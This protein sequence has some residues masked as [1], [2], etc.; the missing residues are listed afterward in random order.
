MPRTGVLRAALGAAIALS[1]ACARVP[2]TQLAFA[3]G[4]DGVA[5]GSPLPCTVDAAT[6]NAGIGALP[7]PG[8]D[9]RVLSWNLHKNEDPG[10]ATD[11]A[12]FA[13]VSDLL[14]IQES[15]LT[16]GLQRVLQ[17]PA[18]IG[19]SRAPSC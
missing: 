16:A 15:A 6:A 10:W 12:R 2:P 5:V 3:L 19:S 7:L 9:F 17:T 18:T 8:P 13:A 11:L 14:L 1:A 4:G